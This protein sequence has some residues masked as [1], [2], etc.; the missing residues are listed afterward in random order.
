MYSCEK[1]RDQSS[2][3]ELV[4]FVFEISKN[5]SLTWDVYANIHNDSILATL[6]AKTDLSKLVASFTHKGS[7]VT[8]DG[9]VQTSGAT[10]NDFRSPVKY[11]VEAED[12]STQTYVASLKVAPIAEQLISKFEIKKSLNPG[13]GEDIVFTI[14]STAQTME[15]VHL[16]WINSSA[17]SQLVVSFTAG[18]AEVSINGGKIE[19]GVTVV[20]FKKPVQIESVSGDYP[21]RTYTATLI[22]PQINA[23][24][25]VMRLDADGPILNDVDYVKARLE[26]LGNGIAEGLWDY[27]ME[28]IEIRLR[29]NSTQG[30]P[31]KPYR[32]KFPEKYSPL[33][34]N[35]AREKSWVLLAND[36]DKSLIRN[37]VAFRISRIMQ[38]GVSY[39]PFTASTQFVDV[40]LNG[41]YEGNYILTDQIEVAPGRVEVKSLEAGDAGNTAKISGGY[42]LEIDGFADAEPLHFTSPRGMKVTVKYPDEDD[43]APEQTA[44]ITD[45]F[46]TTEDV[47]FSADF[48]DPANGWRKHIDRASWVDYCIINELAGN[49][50]AW[51]STYMSKERDVDYFVIGPVW[52]FDI[53][54]NNDNRLVNATTRLMAEAAHDPKTWISRFMQDETFKAAM[55][56]RW[57]E[58][59]GELLSVNEYI[60]ELVVL[61][62]MSQKANFKRWNIKEQ[63]LGHA[64]PAPASYD[65]AITQLKNYFQTRYD[66]L[67]SEF[68]K[69]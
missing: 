58:K 60:D 49:S 36:S 25:P 20:D 47:L 41:R 50:D 12:G 3:K 53:A 19:N 28:K 30:L 9:E 5:S 1:D 66:F 17:P 16:T 54:F 52:D 14:N 65:A 59:K 6:P 27:G 67:D 56:S 69:W 10:V 55:K 42:F 26:I 46:K 44:W 43:Y 15:G 57:N 51:W 63:A 62:D 68:N 11:V 45:F 48:K 34:L 33:G 13:L 32:I 39:R 31:K 23:T 21:P 37:A 24:L 38:T 7:A 35:H 2:E 29:G 4:S 64:N 61:L 8:V 22:C 40:Y 18:D